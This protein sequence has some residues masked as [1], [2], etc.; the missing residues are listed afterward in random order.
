MKG[1]HFDIIAHAHFHDGKRPRPQLQSDSCSLDIIFIC[2]SVWED[3]FTVYYYA[4]HLQ[5]L[6]FSRIV[7]IY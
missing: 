3:S 6:L 5:P 1:C 2:D 4:L 7:S